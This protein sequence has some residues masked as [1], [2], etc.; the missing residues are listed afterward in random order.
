ML[1]VNEHNWMATDKKTE[2][3]LNRHSFIILKLNKLI[4][5]SLKS[6]HSCCTVLAI[7]LWTFK[8]I[9]IN[10]MD[11]RSLNNFVHVELNIYLIFLTSSNLVISTVRSPNCMLTSQLPPVFNDVWRRCNMAIGDVQFR[12]GRG[13]CQDEETRACTYVSA[14]AVCHLAEWQLEQSESCYC[15]P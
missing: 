6:H 1:H 10:P 3:Y 7:I 15:S 11:L 5:W 4:H 12:E 14:A 13:L 9:K 2:H 8:L